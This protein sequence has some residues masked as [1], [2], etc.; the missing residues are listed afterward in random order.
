M[1]PSSSK[2][3]SYVNLDRL[4][5]QLFDLQRLTHE[6][7]PVSFCPGGQMLNVLWEWPQN[8]ISAASTT[9]CCT[10]SARPADS[11]RAAPSLPAG[12][13]NGEYAQERI[14]FNSACAD[15]PG[16]IW[17][18]GCSTTNE[19]LSA[20][21]CLNCSSIPFFICKANVLCHKHT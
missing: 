9:S 4:T 7:M 6:V 21:F 12:L 11:T 1:A 5:S 17:L 18:M 8:S 3:M 19:P 14:K 2:R 10:I 13:H 20:H 15:V 16:A